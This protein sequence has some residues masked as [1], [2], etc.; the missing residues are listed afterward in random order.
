VITQPAT[1]GNL[2]GI[3]PECEAMMYRR[4]NLA[5]LEQVRGKLDIAMPRVL[6]EG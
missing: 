2:V 5:R 6:P 4:V 1:L 3:C